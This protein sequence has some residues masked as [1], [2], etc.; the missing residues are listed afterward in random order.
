MPSIHSC[1]P[2]QQTKA[3]PASKV[4]TRSRQVEETSLPPASAHHSK[5][6]VQPCSPVHPPHRYALPRA[7]RAPP[8]QPV[9]Q[10]ASTST[11]DGDGGSR[12]GMYDRA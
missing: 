11:W 6:S 3:K 12:E 10:E 1:Q 2:S 4:S 8:T 5:P 7:Q 9:N